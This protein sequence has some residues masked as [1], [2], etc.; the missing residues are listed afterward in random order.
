MAE[1]KKQN[2]SGNRRGPK[3]PSKYHK[4]IK[5]YMANSNQNSEIENNKY[6]MARRAWQSHC[7]EEALK[8]PVQ[9]KPRGR[10]R[11]NKKP[12]NQESKRPRGRPRSLSSYLKEFRESYHSGKLLLK[13]KEYSDF[14]KNFLVQNQKE[15]LEIMKEHDYRPVKT[16]GRPKGSKNKI[17]R[18]VIIENDL[19]EEEINFEDLGQPE[20]LE[21]MNIKLEKVLS[22]D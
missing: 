22:S 18:E 14:V 21:D 10:P 3:G 4:F 17:N 9:K 15:L 20:V 12:E 2:N 6:Q 1:V 16:R 11:S 8:N 19:Q 13:E 5:N 7:N